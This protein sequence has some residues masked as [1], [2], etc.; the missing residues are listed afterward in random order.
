MR[1]LT[2]RMT[3]FYKFIFPTVW[4]GGFS[5]GTFDALSGADTH[6]KADP[7]DP[8]FMFPRQDMYS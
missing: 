6:A 2:S 4:I 8:V 3:F 5:M 1:Q 7:N